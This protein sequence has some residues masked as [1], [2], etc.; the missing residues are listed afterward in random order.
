[1]HFPLLW[2]IQ[3]F[4]CVTSLQKHPTAGSISRQSLCRHVG[5]TYK[6][7]GKQH[8]STGKPHRI[9]E[10]SRLGGSPNTVQGKYENRMGKLPNIQD[11]FRVS[12]GTSSPYTCTGKLF[13]NGKTIRM[14]WVG[15]SLTHNHLTVAILKVKQ[16]NQLDLLVTS[17]F[18]SL[19]YVCMTL[20]QITLA[21]TLKAVIVLRGLLIEYV[22]IK[23]FSEDFLTDDGRVCS[24]FL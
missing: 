10:Q 12:A 4:N 11:Q 3:Q 5:V 20:L 7:D 16:L 22:S 24:Y 6:A 23:A 21:K 15:E 18:M 9:C 19:M 17:P 1:M 2:Q 13:G 8:S 14:Q